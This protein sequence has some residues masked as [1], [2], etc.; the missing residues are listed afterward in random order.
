MKVWLNHREIE[1]EKDQILA[2]FLADQKLN[3]ASGIAVAVN[4]TIVPKQNWNTSE[5]KNN[6]KIM[7]ITA[8]AGG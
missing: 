1:I 6:D 4:E 5:L 2:V 3:Q 7:V 8:T